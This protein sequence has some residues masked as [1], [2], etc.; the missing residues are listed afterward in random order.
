MTVA[1]VDNF[2]KP[3]V[4]YLPGL[5][6]VVDDLGS[7]P[8]SSGIGSYMELL[9]AQWRRLIDSREAADERLL[10]AFFFG[11]ASKRPSRVAYGGSLRGPLAISVRGYIATKTAWPVNKDT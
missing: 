1:E 11:T 5:A 6:D 9:H 7:S 8:W 2:R 4:G 10:Q 3:F